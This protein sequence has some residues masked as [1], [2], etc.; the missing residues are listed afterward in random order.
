[1]QSVQDA[2]AAHGERYLQRVYTPGELRDCG[3]DAGIDPTRLAAR[4]AAKEA[5]MKVLRRG[6]EA[7]AWRSI[8][9][10]RQPGGRPRVELT[11]D[12]DALARDSGLDDLALSIT[13]EHDYAAAVVVADTRPGA[14]S[15]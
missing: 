1:M 6:D 5:T 13:H 9:V 4:F 12:A 14:G 7:V 8:G 2:I 11:G 3:G 10:T 15:R